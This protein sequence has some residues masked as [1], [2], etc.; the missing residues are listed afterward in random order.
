MV[1]SD[2]AV[3]IGKVPEAQLDVRGEHLSVTAL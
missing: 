2:T 1:I 3:G